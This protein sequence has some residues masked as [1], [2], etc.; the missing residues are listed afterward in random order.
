MPLSWSPI[1]VL[2]S[3]SV[4]VIWTI[5][6]SVSSSTSDGVRPITPSLAGLQDSSRTADRRL[7]LAAALLATLAYDHAL[8]VLGRYMMRG[9][10]LDRRRKAGSD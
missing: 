3:L 9:L 8:P 10:T 5:Y 4:H 7:V 1:A 6:S 2:F